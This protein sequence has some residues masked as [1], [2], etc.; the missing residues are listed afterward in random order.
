MYNRAI[1]NTWG[2]WAK[3]CPFLKPFL[4]HRWPKVPSR[5]HRGS[6]LTDHQ[7]L[8]SLY[9]TSNTL[10]FLKKTKQTC[11]LTLWPG[12]HSSSRSAL[13]ENPEAFALPSHFTVHS[14]APAVHLPNAAGATAPGP[15]CFDQVEANHWSVEQEAG[16]MAWY[17]PQWQAARLWALLQ[18][19]QSCYFLTM[20]LKLED[21]CN[22]LPTKL[23]RTFYFI[24][25]LRFM[26]ASGIKC[27]QTS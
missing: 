1:H 9:F 25:L 20:W 24:I 12:A 22:F 4:Q 26:S 5:H 17:G 23:T 8:C 3:F 7:T 19:W 15:L 6:F 2:F 27:D 16:G 11:T 10:F 18:P 21:C 13:W 14:L